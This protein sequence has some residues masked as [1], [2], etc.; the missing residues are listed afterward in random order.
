LPLF[1][2]H[3]FF[4]YLY[5]LLLRSTTDHCRSR[6]KGREGP[7]LIRSFIHGDVSLKKQVTEQLHRGQP[8]P[9]WDL[10]LAPSES[11]VASSPLLK[12]EWAYVHVLLFSPQCS[13]SPIAF[14][15]W[16]ALSVKNTS[17][18]LSPPLWDVSFEAGSFANLQ[19]ETPGTPVSLQ[20]NWALP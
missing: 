4:I 7:P 19:I 8:D 3:V 11:K 10:N 2:C 14:F 9:E 16:V 12:P 17:F 20:L 18:N 13:Y 15:S 1:A 6:C 5:V